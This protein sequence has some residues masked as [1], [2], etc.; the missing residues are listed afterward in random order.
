L[1]K[2]AGN[3]PK[4]LV[5]SAHGHELS[6]NLVIPGMKAPGDE[7]S[8]DFWLH[9]NVFRSIPT[10]TIVH[11]SSCFGGYP[12]AMAIQRRAR[13][14][15]PIIGPLVDI[16]FDDALRLHCALLNH[17]DERG[18]GD[19]ELREFVDQMQREFSAS[20]RYSDRFAVGLIDRSHRQHPKEAVGTQLAATVGESRIS[21]VV[22]SVDFRNVA[23]EIDA[24]GIGSITEILDPATQGDIAK[25]FR[26]NIPADRPCRQ[27]R[28]P[29]DSLGDF[30]ENSDYEAMCGRTFTARY[31]VSGIYSTEWWGL[32]LDV[33]ASDIKCEELV[34]HGKCLRTIS[35]A[36]TSP[37][38]IAKT[39]DR[40]GYKAK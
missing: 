6:G 21:F 33:K 13:T 35:D 31:Q 1:S 9:G 20:Q 14:V 18:D 38:A 37:I 4:V 12:N 16:F 26:L 22:E 39:T 36:N 25:G 40:F 30:I 10:Q 11:L 34:D 8:I 7:Q 3:L 5:I 32:L 23:V 29:L 28:V 19:A 2:I 17:L 15:P 24:S 27:L